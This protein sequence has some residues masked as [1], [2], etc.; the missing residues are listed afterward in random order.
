[1]DHRVQRLHPP[2]HHLGKAGEVG[3]V[4]HLQPRFAQRAAVPPVETSSTPALAPACLPSSTNTGLVGH[5]KQCPPDRHRPSCCVIY[6]ILLS[7]QAKFPPPR[8][9]IPS[10]TNC[11]TGCGLPSPSTHRLSSIVE[12][13]SAPGR[14]TAT[15]SRRAAP[16]WRPCRSRPGRLDLAA[17]VEADGE[18]H[19]AAL[20]LAARGD[21]HVLAAQFAALVAQHQDAAMDQAE[22]RGI[23]IVARLDPGGA[24]RCPASTVRACRSRLRQRPCRAC[25]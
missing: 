8:D 18:R 9:A 5:R 17:E 3:Y 12:R 24:S 6:P 13:S 21:E 25:R 7:S 10:I 23:A 11:C 20:A 16:G 14:G 22:A 1:M 2:V 19:L 15:G 4:A